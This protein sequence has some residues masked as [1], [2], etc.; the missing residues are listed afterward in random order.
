VKNRSIR[1]GLRLLRKPDVRKLF[2]AYLI[3]YTGTA[4][5]PIAMA[6]GVLELTGSTSDSAIVI[7]APTLA[8]IVVLLLGGVLADRTSRQRVMVFAELLAMLA[9]LAIAFLFLTELATVPVLVLLALINGVAIALNTPASTG[10]VTQLVEKNELQRLNAL[11][12]IARNGAVTGGAALGGLLVAFFGAGITLM[13]DALSFGLSALL[14]ISLKP[15][16]QIAPE[17]ASFLH[18]V[19]LGWKEFTSHTWLWVVVLQ[20]A[21]VVAAFESVIGLLG[22]AIARNQM[23]GAADWGFIADSLGAG[24]LTG[25]L[26]AMKINAKYPMRS[27]TYCVFLLSAIPL[28]LA[29][30]LPV[31]AIACTA[32]L[33]GT[34][35]QIFAV[36]WYTTL[37]TKVPNH[38]LS[39]VSAYD[40]LGSIALAPIGIV[41]AGFLFEKIGAQLTLFFT[42]LTIILPTTLV[43]AVRDVRMMT[44]DRQR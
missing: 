3:S 29:V 43:L 28:A 20:F 31:T 26:V 40:H 21:F 12:G 25:G 42:A 14:V 10:M 38:M 1:E 19:R 8:S 17:K 33:A 44:N 9:Q 30:P 6:F 23:G 37:Q 41:V 32:F 34:G 4:M 39:R 13:L 24:T 16:N 22:P 5:A 2:I 11:L 7:A 18:D 27:G 36:I 35:I 15:S